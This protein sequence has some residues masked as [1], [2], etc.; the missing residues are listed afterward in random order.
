MTF[1][2][3]NVQRMT[4]MHDT[5]LCNFLKIEIELSS[6]SALERQH[7]KINKIN[8][9]NRSKNNYDLS[10]IMNYVMTHNIFFFSL[11]NCFSPTMSLEDCWPSSGYRILFRFVSYLVDNLVNGRAKQFN[12]IKD[13]YVIIISIVI[14]LH[15]LLGCGFN[16]KNVSH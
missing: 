7:I 1:A 6:Q 12:V 8:K 16:R 9:I 2:K 5:T 4:P 11:R 14:H 3:V 15:N 13:Y 10:L